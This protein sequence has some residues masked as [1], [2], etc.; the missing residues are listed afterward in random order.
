MK[1]KKLTAVFLTLLIASFLAVTA[2]AVDLP[3]KSEQFYVLDQ[4][5][6]ISSDT[7]KYIV[8]MNEILE[9]KT[10]AQIVVVTQDFVQD[11]NLELYAYN[12]FNKWEIGSK[13]KNN[14]VLLL[15][16]IG[17]D[18]Y[19]CMTG[20]GLEK[21]LSSG[22]L[23]DI[24]YDYLEDDFA[25]QDYDAGVRKTF[26]AIYK[27]LADIYSMDL[28]DEMT[29][30]SSS[31]TT[32][33]ASRETDKTAPDENRQ[34]SKKRSNKFLIILIII[35]VILILANRGGRR[36]RGGGGNYRGGGSGGFFTGMFLGNMIGRNSRRG[37]RN[38]PPPPPRGD[39]GRGSGG[40]RSGH[41]GGGSRPGSFGGSSRGGFGGSGRSGGGSFG[42][43]HSG[44]GGSTRGGGAGRR[45]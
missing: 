38:P 31:K 12:L 8:S 29:G 9:E 35:V 21:T 23:G 34:T 24:L 37:W 41:F 30:N 3:E 22:T 25:K 20:K 42:G 7:E 17:D 19:W 27:K 14:G 11:G 45:H 43:R 28:P 4:S 44:G 18:N 39:F 5:D 33:P 40:H 2:A 36:P 10:G 1:I 15:L 6:V 16:S 26:D 32:S 13:E